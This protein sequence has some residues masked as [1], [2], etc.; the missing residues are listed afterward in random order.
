MTRATALERTR[1][2]IR[3]VRSELSVEDGRITITKGSPTEETPRSVSFGVDQVRGSALELPPRGG[4]GWLHV[5]VAGGSPT[6]PG[7]LA[8]AGDPY[9]LPITPRSLRAAR[10]LGRLIEKHVR[11]RGMPSEA[12]PNEGR[13]SSGVNLT[14]PDD[15]TRPVR[16]ASQ[17]PRLAER[18]TGVDTRRTPR[19]T[20]GVAKAGERET[21]AG[22]GA[23][24]RAAGRLVVHLREL[25]DLRDAG[26][27]SDE[28][29]ERAKA[30]LLR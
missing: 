25:A 19:P 30:R 13:Y 26:V 29:F 18:R 17:A 20:D 2:V 14:S 11:E 10:K 9:T 23:R 8:A 28:E 27:L 6:P 15:H 4:R 1:F 5:A 3:G 16:A 22:A 7:E 24:E 21:G 12:G